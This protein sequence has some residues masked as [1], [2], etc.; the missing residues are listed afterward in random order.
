MFN[1]HRQ[2]HS[3]VSPGRVKKIRG[4]FKIAS[5]AS[6]KYMM[7]YI[8]FIVAP[9]P[10]WIIVPLRC[11][12]RIATWRYRTNRRV[13][14]NRRHA[15]ARDTRDNRCRLRIGGDTHEDQQQRGGKTRGRPSRNHSGY[16]GTA[17]G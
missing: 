8:I 5:R 17:E 13:S 12:L 9:L 1:P 7:A 3:P 6:P 4:T 10:T 16:S 2:R 15:V 11:D 14:N